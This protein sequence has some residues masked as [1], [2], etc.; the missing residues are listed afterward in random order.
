MFYLVK[1]APF[2]YY[3]STTFFSGSHAELV[4]AQPPKSPPTQTPSIAYLKKGKIHNSLLTDYAT[5]IYRY[6]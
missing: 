4:S 1:H 6:L 3:S 5:F 2:F